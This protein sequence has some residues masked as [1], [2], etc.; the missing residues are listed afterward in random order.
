VALTLSHTFSS[1]HVSDD[2][3]DSLAFFRAAGS[4]LMVQREE[5]FVD[6]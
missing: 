6:R 4:S 5:D 1:A 3:L 2:I